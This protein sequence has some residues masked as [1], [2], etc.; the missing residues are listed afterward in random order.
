MELISATKSSMN[1]IL[2]EYLDA[3]KGSDLR[4]LV[5]GGRVVACMK[6]SSTDGSFKAN[7]SR[8][9][10]VEQFDPTPEIEWLAVEAARILGLDITGIDL[11]FDKG[12]YFKIC[13]A[14]SS[15]GFKGIEACVKVD[16]PH[17]IFSFVAVRQGKMG[18]IPRKSQKKKKKEK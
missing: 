8:G 9:G 3:S 6:R 12:G 7:A 10:K 4:V 11:L 18:M 14:N 15:P 1:F 2:Q 13:E 17:E 16:V 5:I